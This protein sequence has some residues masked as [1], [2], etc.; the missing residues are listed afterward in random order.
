MTTVAG[1]ANRHHR[2]RF[3][4]L[5]AQL[6]ARLREPADVNRT[7]DI[8]AISFGNRHFFRGVVRFDLHAMT[9]RNPPET[10]KISRKTP[11]HSV[12]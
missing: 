3:Q 10:A 11:T 8:C 7:S 12:E 1:G 6:P 2:C 4:K 5:T 9:D